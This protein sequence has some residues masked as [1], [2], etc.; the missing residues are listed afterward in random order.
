M[1]AA[2]VYLGTA[3]VA[4]TVGMGLGTLGRRWSR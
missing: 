2:L 1:T 4:W 3:A